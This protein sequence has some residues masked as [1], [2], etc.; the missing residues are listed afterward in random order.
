VLHNLKIDK[1]KTKRV[2]HIVES[3]WWVSID[4]IEVPKLAFVRILSSGR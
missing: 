2:L 4:K 3:E 1:R